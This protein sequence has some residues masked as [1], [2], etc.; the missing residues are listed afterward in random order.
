MRL[1]HQQRVA[2]GEVHQAGRSGEFVQSFINVVLLFSRLRQ[3]ST[4]LTR[5]AHGASK[6]DAKPPADLVQIRP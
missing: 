5:W 3:H 2:L 1:R 6:L 4:Q